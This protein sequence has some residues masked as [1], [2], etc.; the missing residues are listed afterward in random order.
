MEYR[1]QFLL[2][3]LAWNGGTLPVFH[4]FYIEGNKC[5]MCS[6]RC[7]PSPMPVLY[8]V[9]KVSIFSPKIFN[10]SVGLMRDLVSGFVI[11]ISH[12]AEDLGIL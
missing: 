10:M 6:S 7:P 12:H 5:Q 3:A 1:C 2:A 11:G 4:L 9:P 8:R